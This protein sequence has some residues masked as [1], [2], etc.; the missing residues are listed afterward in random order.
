M[1]V[2]DLWEEYEVWGYVELRGE[3]RVRG[4]VFEKREEEESLGS[5]SWRVWWGCWFFCGRE[6]KGVRW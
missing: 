1:G 6:I 3:G 4:G 5:E 2:Y